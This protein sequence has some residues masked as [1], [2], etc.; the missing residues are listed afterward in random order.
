MRLSLSAVR[1]ALA[2]AAAAGML[3]SA[4]GHAQ[5]G[6]TQDMGAKFQATYVWQSKPA[7]P[8]RYTGPNSLAPWRERGYS[9]SA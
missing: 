2:T 5:S 6:A 8:A 1:A 3:V 7:F 9:F 4:P